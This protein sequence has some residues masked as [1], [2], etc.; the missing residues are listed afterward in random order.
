LVPYAGLRVEKAS[1]QARLSIRQWVSGIIGEREDIQGWRP[2]NWR[3]LVILPFVGAGVRGDP[4][5][6]VWRGQKREAIEALVLVVLK[7]CVITNIILPDHTTANHVNST[8]TPVE[9]G[10]TI[11]RRSSAGRRV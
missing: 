5:H 1:K 8:R 2:Q 6:N 9:D 7:L 4:K 11:P 10:Y 3:I